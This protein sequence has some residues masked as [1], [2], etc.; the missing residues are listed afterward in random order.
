MKK[1]HRTNKESY[2]IRTHLVHGNYDIKH[3]DY[4]HHVVPPISASC[5]A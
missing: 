1:E 2:R 3:W 4:D 5:Q